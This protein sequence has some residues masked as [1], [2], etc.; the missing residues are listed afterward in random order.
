[1]PP[2]SILHVCSEVSPFIKTGGIADVCEAM[3][4]AL[5]RAGVR[6]TVVMPRYGTIDPVH[7]ALAKRLTPITV[8]LGAARESITV[9]EGRL[10]GGLVT[11]YLLD[12]PLFE[13]PGVYGE[14]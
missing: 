2:L 14:G 10:P 13:R 5:A 6:T 3:P 4:R 1:M 12:H 11:V 9:Y 8:P 7:H